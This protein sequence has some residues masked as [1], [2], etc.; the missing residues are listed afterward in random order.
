M[1]KKE[2][3]E[4]PEPYIRE[5]ILVDQIKEFY[6]E[7]FFIKKLKIA[8]ENIKDSIKSMGDRLPVVQLLEDKNSLNFKNY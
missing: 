5:E 2:R 1:E 8:H 4:H 3:N 7:D 6:G